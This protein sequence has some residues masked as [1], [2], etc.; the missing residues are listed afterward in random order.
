MRRMVYLVCIK[1]IGVELVDLILK[2]TRQ[3]GEEK[4]G[5]YWTGNEHIV[6]VLQLAGIV[7]QLIY[8]QDFVNGY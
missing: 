8:F 4:I 1:V 2:R 7:V 3:D 6:T 5:T